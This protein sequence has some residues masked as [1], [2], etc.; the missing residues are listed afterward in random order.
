MSPEQES[1]Y[2]DEEGSL[3][4]QLPCEAALDRAEED[5]LVG[6]LHTEGRLGRRHAGFS[7]MLRVAAALVLVAS[8]GWAGMHIGD[9]DPVEAA[10]A[11]PDLSAQE[12]VLLLQRTGSAYVQAAHL[13]AA[14]GRSPDSAAVEVAL[15]VLVG[16]AHAIA[17]ADRDGTLAPRLEQL[18]EREFRPPPSTGERVIWF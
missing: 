9:R 5:Q 16:A 10:L 2:K 6:R 13:Q 15:R 1:G 18:L 17:R 4:R 3:L 11:R 14:Q 12:R 7:W 8:G